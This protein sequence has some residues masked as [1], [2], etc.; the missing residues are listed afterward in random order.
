MSETTTGAALA[1]LVAGS[2]FSAGVKASAQCETLEPE[3]VLSVAGQ[4]DADLAAGPYPS[5]LE[6]VTVDASTDAVVTPRFEASPALLPPGVSAEWTIPLEVYRTLVAAP[7][8]AEDPQSS[9]GPLVQ[10][11]DSWLTSPLQGEALPF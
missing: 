4:A 3:R 6:V 1:L 11:I 7:T 2:L 8:V 5:L 9:E 10:S